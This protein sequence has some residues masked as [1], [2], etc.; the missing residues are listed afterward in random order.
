MAWLVEQHGA[1]MDTGRHVSL[2]VIVLSRYMSRSGHK[3]NSKA[4]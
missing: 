3:R 2:R 4:S 1:A